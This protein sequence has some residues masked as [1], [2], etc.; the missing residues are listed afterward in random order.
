MVERYIN[1][2][3]EHLRKVVA[4]HQSSWDEKLHLFLLAYGASTHDTTGASPVRLVF[5]RELRLPCDLLFGAPPDTER[6]TTDRATDIVDHLH[7]IQDYAQKDLK[8]A[9]DRLKTRYDE[10]ASSA[11]YHEGGQGVALSYNFHER[12]I[13]QSSIIMGRPIQNNHPN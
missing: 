10:L 12:E 6:P 3:E 11:G 4:S 2:V 8:L 13:A 9:S 5:G 1:T 7:D